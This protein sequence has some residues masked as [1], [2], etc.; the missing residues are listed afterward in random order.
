MSTE[1][2]NVMRIYYWCETC[3]CV[4]CK[5]SARDQ[6]LVSST[7]STHLLLTSTYNVPAN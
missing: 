1:P 4:I 7:Q 3:F 6:S 2:E 5:Y